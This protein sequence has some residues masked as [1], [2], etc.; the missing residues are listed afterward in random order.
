MVARYG[1]R[2]GSLATK[3]FERA[4]SLANRFQMTEPRIVARLAIVRVLLGLEPAVTP[5][6]RRFRQEAFTRRGQ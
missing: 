6:G 4:Q 1:Q 5:T 3:D 2:L